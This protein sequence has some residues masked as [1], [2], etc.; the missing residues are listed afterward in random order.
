MVYKTQ[1][2]GKYNIIE[3]NTWD[4]LVTLSHH[5][6]AVNRKSQILMLSSVSVFWCFVSWFGLWKSNTYMH[7]VM[8]KMWPLIWNKHLRVSSV[9]W[10]T[11][12]FIS[13]TWEA[14]SNQMLHYYFCKL[15][16][17]SNTNQSLEIHL[18]VSKILYLL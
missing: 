7:F 13:S 2:C 15:P 11:N 18:Y 14:G 17:P 4:F 12:H 9:M 1:K 10:W 8:G 3:W 6:L 5:G 16:S